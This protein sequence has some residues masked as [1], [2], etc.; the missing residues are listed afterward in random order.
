MRR[1]GEMH[2]GCYTFLLLLLLLVT[3]GRSVPIFGFR[4]PVDCN[5]I[6]EV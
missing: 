4:T 5:L 6:V 3:L 1:E 2:T